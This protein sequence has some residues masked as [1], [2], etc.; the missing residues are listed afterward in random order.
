MKLSEMNTRKIFLCAVAIAA[1][2]ALAIICIKKQEQLPRAEQNK[3]SQSKPL[4][5]MPTSGKKS[6]VPLQKRSVL[7][8]ANT[9]GHVPLRISKG[10]KKFSCLPFLKE[11]SMNYRTL[12]DFRHQAVRGDVA[13]W[14]E[15]NR[16]LRYEYDGENWH[17]PQGNL[18][19][20]VKF[21]FGKYVL[22]YE[23]T[24]EATTEIMFSGE[25]DVESA[26]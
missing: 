22:T 19:D 24:E 18:A 4:S 6:G 7:R 13:S 17:D 5:D 15:G 21:D 16:E 2:A 1:V 25:L 11:S 3:P 9:V 12:G 10:K 26:P 20:D 14:K 8:M 23:R